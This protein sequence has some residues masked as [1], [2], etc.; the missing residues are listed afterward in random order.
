MKSWIDGRVI[1]EKNSAK[2]T[3]EIDN[4]RKVSIRLPTPAKAVKFVLLFP[5]QFVF[6]S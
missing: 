2:N 4:L 3:N 6:V 5:I 1:A